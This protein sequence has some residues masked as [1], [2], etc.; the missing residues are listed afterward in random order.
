MHKRQAVSPNTKEKETVRE[1]SCESRKHNTEK[2]LQAVSRRNKKK[3]TRKRTHEETE[4]I[5][6][7]RTASVYHHHTFNL[8]LELLSFPYFL[9][10]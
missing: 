2:Q 5:L 1:E 8:A 6:K 9:C 4:E 3:K 7:T 10:Q